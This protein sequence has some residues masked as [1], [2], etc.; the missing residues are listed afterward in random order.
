MLKLLLL[1]LSLS[2][3]GADKLDDALAS[4]IFPATSNKCNGAG[5]STSF[6]ATYTSTAGV[7]EWDVNNAQYED[8]VFEVDMI[9]SDANENRTWTLRLGKGGQ[10]ASFRVASGEAIA[11]QANPSAAWNDLVQQMVAV[12]NDLNKPADPNFIHQAGPYMKDTG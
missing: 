4:A 3:V 2:R 6:S 10:I 9:H 12:N 5:S 1:A 7:S 11:N 8:D